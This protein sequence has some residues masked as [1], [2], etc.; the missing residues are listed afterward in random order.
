MTSSFWEISI[1]ENGTQGKNFF[2]ARPI[3]PTYRWSLV[4][5]QF[6]ERHLHYGSGF[7]GVQRLFSLVLRKR[8]CEIIIRLN[9]L[10][11]SWSVDQ[12]INSLMK[13][14][15]MKSQL[16]WE[17]W[18]KEGYGGLDKTVG[19]ETRN[20]Y[21]RNFD[22]KVLGK[23]SHEWTNWYTGITLRRILGKWV[24]RVGSGW[25]RLSNSVVGIATG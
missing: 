21:V 24:V 15:Y 22:R 19:W 12:Q 4:I 16:I 14:C 5:Q 17:R 11:Y 20:P 3:L 7:R 2:C 13:Y 23:C 18:N 1:L 6:P 8:S 10:V 25:N 9:C